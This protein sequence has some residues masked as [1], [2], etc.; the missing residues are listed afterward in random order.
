MPYPASDLYPSSSVFPGGEAPVAV[1]GAADVVTH[2][3]ATLNGTVDPRG[4]GTDY[5][6]EYGETVAYGFIVPAGRDGDAGSGGS[7]IAVDEAISGLS[8][9]TIYH[10]RLVAVNSDGIDV[11][12]DES[13]QTGALLDVAMPGAANAGAEAPDALTP[14]QNPS[15]TAPSA[16]A[17]AS[18]THVVV[19]DNEQE[20]LTL[21]VT[22]IT[23][24][25]A[26]F[27]G[28]VDPNGEPTTY[29]FEHVTEEEFQDTIWATAVAT[30]SGR[31]GDAGSGSEPVAVT[32][33]VS[34]LD[35]G[36]E[37]RCRLVARGT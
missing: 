14:E 20:L 32:E 22:A 17:A 25:S 3:S 7:P 33:K 35:P 29:W 27:N 23:R 12:D 15:P 11:G 2:D 10:F 26:R 37:Y 24:S 1:T 9:E 8:R 19:A 31:D 13:F 30:P 36:V 28:T 5:Y 16:A 6:F 21:R 4:G 34:G 18:D